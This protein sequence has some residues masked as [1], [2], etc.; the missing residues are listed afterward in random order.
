M[1]SKVFGAHLANDQCEEALESVFNPFLI[2]IP[3]NIIC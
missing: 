3:I 1:W 2:I